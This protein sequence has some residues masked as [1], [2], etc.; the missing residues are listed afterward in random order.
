MRPIHQLNR[1]R[2]ECFGAFV[3]GVHNP[4]NSTYSCRQCGQT[5]NTEQ[6]HRRGDGVAVIPAHPDRR[7]PPKLVA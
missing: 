5:Y 2:E 7:G 3:T 4:E 1:P 6:L